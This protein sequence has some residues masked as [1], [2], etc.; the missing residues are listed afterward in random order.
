VLAVFTHQGKL[1]RAK[2]LAL[3]ED[4]HKTAM[5]DDEGAECFDRR[6]V[7]H[8]AISVWC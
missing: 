7:F 1:L 5:L 3:L 8:L 2:S 4:F 6:E